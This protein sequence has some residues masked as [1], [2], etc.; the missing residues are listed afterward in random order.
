MHFVK[1]EH[2]YMRENIF[3]YTWCFNSSLL[4]IF[5]HFLD[6][7][8]LFHSK[9]FYRFHHFKIKTFKHIFK[10]HYKYNFRYSGLNAYVGLVSIKKIIIIS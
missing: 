4:S 10:D 2:S 8:P 3:V 9:G 5:N 6:V 7:W 1:S